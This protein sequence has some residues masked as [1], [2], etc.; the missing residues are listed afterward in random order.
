MNN[1]GN[2]TI[3]Y[4]Q[5]IKDLAKDKDFLLFKDDAVNSKTGV[6]VIGRHEYYLEIL[7]KKDSSNWWEMINKGLNNFF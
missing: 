3:A 6:V 7:H 2:T 1:K 5:F 4:R